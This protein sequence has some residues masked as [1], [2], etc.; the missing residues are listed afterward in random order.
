MNNKCA[1]CGKDC[2]KRYWLC[3]LDM[4]SQQW[5][6]ECFDLTECGK[7]LEGSHGEGCSTLVQ[8]A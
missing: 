6:D 8:S 1:S 4:D 5:C 7:G 3:D 2:A